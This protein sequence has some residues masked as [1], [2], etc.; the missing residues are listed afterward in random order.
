MWSGM[1]FGVMSHALLCICI[2]FFR[3]FGS[4]SKSMVSSRVGSHSS[5]V[6]GNDSGLVCGGSSSTADFCG[7]AGLADVL[8]RDDGDACVVGG[9][10]IGTACCGGGVKV[11]DDAAVAAAVAA[12]ALASDTGG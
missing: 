2:V 8:A 6:S 9:A 1:V 10:L 3:A 5:G 4:I 11:E 12:A 7:E